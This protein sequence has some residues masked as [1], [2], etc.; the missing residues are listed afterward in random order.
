MFYGP[1]NMRPLDPNIWPFVC[2][3]CMEFFDINRAAERIY[4]TVQRQKVER[5]EKA[6]GDWKRARLA[7]CT[8][9]IDIDD[10]DEATNEK[11]YGMD[12]DSMEAPTLIMGG[13]KDGKDKG[14][15]DEDCEEGGE[16]EEKVEDEEEE[17]ELVDHEEHN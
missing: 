5:G 16:E 9:L 3:A 12:S 15:K 17:P 7:S 8:D 10:D 11:D 6:A 13:G 14:E 2:A 4:A 1:D